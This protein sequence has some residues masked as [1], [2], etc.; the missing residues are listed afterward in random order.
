MFQPF[1][2]ILCDFLVYMGE[3]LG[4]GDYIDRGDVF[5]PALGKGIKETKGIDRVAP[6][7][8]PDGLGLAR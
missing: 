4:A 5:G 7:L 2:Q 6:E 1:A 3:H 8:C